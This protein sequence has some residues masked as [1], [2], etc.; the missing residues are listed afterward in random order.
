MYSSHSKCEHTYLNDCT[1][2]VKIYIF[3]LTA[4]LQC[5]KDLLDELVLSRNNS[6]LSIG[7]KRQNRSSFFI[8]IKFLYENDVEEE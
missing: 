4:F 3:V 5:T 6:D 8:L 1:R 7:T 2:A